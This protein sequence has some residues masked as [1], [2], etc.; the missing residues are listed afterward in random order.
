MTMISYSFFTCNNL[1]LLYMKNN[2][3]SVISPLLTV[4]YQTYGTFPFHFD[5]E[6]ALARNPKRL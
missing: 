6:I 4:S 1:F 3:I 5:D 2:V